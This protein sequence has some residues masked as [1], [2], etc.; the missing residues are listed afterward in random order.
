MDTHLEEVTHMDNIK[1]SGDGRS[2]V[3]ID[4]TLLPT[5]WNT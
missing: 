3:I 2:V 1:L 4:Q 5:G